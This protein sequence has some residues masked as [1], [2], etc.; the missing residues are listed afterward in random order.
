MA[1]II[2]GLTFSTKSQAERHIRWILSRYANGSAIQDADEQFVLTLL[3]THPRR[4]V[5]VDCGIKRIVVQWLDC[6]G[7]QRRFIAIRKDDSRR[8][9]SW[10][11]AIYPR[12]AIEQ[13]RRVCRTLIQDQVYAARRKA[14]SQDIVLT[15]PISGRRI[16]ADDCDI[17]HA[18]P[19]TFAVLVDGWL[20]ANRMEP[21][22]VE[23]I[24]SPDYQQSDCFQD[25]FLADNWRQYHRHHA[26]LRPL[27][28][29]A[30]RSILR[31]RGTDGEPERAA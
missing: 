4:K 26:R 15:C 3:E 28:P 25:E 5:I 27:H 29:I 2:G 23:I 17:D 24:L 6:S 19:N 8:D 12:S 11:Q 14:F 30:N 31:K 13:V 18:P 10:R 22:D 16:T 20:K 7:Q 21:E 1:I 9:F